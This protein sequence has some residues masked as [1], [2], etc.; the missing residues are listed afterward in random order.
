MLNRLLPEDRYLRRALTGLA[1]FL[2]LSIV[3][4][5]L[6]AWDAYRQGEFG[7]VHD[8]VAQIVWQYG[9]A[10]PQAA[11]AVQQIGEMSPRD[12]LIALVDPVTGKAAVAWPTKYT[13]KAPEEMQLDSGVKLPSLQMVQGY[14]SFRL[15]R[16]SPGQSGL[17]KDPVARIQ[18]EVGRNW[19]RVRLSPLYPWRTDRESRHRRLLT[20]LPGPAVT[21]ASAAVS[22]DSSAEPGDD[23]DDQDYGRGYPVIASAPP[24]AYL[25][26]VSTPRLITPLAMSASVIGGLAAIGL[27]V[28][29]LSVAWW[30]FLDARK[31]GN[32]PF[33]WG[34][35]VLLTNLVGAA[36]YLIARRQWLQCANCGAEVE[37]R[38]RHC[39]SCG[40]ALIT[41]CTKCDQ[42]LRRGWT[43]CASCGTTATG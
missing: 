8:D 35:L 10:S 21:P 4:G 31:R 28:Y 24:L 33:A 5:G 18:A 34:L 27:L 12:E 11:G 39:P 40:H 29:W 43:H 7:R 36:I 17:S 30:V 42:P 6:A 15:R 37:K 9:L 3:A 1:A 23:R 2:V 38:F 22:V 25:L 26:V 16:F 41:V 32:L 13:G 19:V 20:V 14:G